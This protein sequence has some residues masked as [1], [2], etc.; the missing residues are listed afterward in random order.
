MIH[1]HFIHIR[2]NYPF[3]YSKPIKF[4]KENDVSKIRI[5]PW[6]IY[7]SW[8]HLQ[9]PFSSSRRK[10][11]VCVIG[12]AL[13][14]SLVQTH[15]LTQRD[16]R[17]R[18]DLWALGSQARAAKASRRPRRWQSEDS[19][20]AGNTQSL[21]SV[22]A[23]AVSVCLACWLIDWP[24]YQPSIYIDL[25]AEDRD[26]VLGRNLGALGIVPGSFIWKIIFL[27]WLFFA[28]LV[29]ISCRFHF[30]SVIKTSISLHHIRFSIQKSQGLK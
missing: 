8:I 15:C 9:N 5:Q 28:L 27:V 19:S 17:R 22:S 25:R 18:A 1:Y 12:G 29:F 30:C 26:W 14:L 3:I 6:K 23:H 4:M 20:G 2:L 13:M 7:W 21:S 16:E 11:R 24:N 10:A